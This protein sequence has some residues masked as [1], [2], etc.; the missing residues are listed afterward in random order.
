ML[1]FN[2]IACIVLAVF[3]A[4]VLELGVFDKKEDKKAYMLFQV[5]EACTIVLFFVSLLIA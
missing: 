4:L 2:S 3:L 5:M 1:S